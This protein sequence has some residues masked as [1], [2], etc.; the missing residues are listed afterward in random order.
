MA[1]YLLCMPID[2][3]FFLIS[4]CQSENADY[5]VG[6][7]ELCAVL[8]VG[9]SERPVDNEYEDADGGID[10][11]RNHQD[12]DDDDD[13]AIIPFECAFTQVSRSKK[14]CSTFVLWDSKQSG[15]PL[16]LSA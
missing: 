11:L 9:S 2:L 12:D 7:N 1:N 4:N 6:T 3:S 5:M 16:I 14:C 15:I 8:T 13:D 10:Q